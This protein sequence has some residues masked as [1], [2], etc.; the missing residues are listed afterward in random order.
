MSRSIGLT[1]LDR[2]GAISLQDETKVKRMLAGRF[3]WALINPICWLR[4]ALKASLVML[5]IAFPVAAFN[6]GEMPGWFDSLFLPLYVVLFLVHHGALAWK[7]MVT[8]GQKMGW[9]E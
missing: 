7:D 1:I 2:E 4:S 8:F 5:L 9:R 3:A 6:G